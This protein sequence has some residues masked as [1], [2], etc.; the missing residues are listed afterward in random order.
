MLRKLYFGHN[1]QVGNSRTCL[2]DTSEGDTD[3]ETTKEQQR[4]RGGMEQNHFELQ[5]PLT[6]PRQTN[7]QRRHENSPSR[8]RNA[9]SR[10]SQRPTTQPITTADNKC[11]HT[12][13]DSAAQRGVTAPSRPEAALQAAITMRQWNEPYIPQ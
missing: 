8:P 2:D 5:G 10:S 6:F 7:T 9:Q 3:Q 1:R 4:P 13:M 11:H 12:E